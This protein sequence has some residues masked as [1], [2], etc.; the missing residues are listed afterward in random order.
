MPANPVILFYHG[1]GPDPGVDKSGIEAR[2]KRADNSDADL[3][4]PIPIPSSGINYSYPKH[5]KI[6]WLTSPNELIQNLVWFVD[7]ADNILGDPALNWDGMTLWAGIT[8]T[9][10]QGVTLDAAALRAGLTDAISYDSASPLSVLADIV[11]G[12]GEIG[13]GMTQQYVLTQLAV[14]PAA[15]SGLKG[16]R[17]VWYRYEEV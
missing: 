4:N 7:P 6:S 17:N 9:Y 5:Q 10:V 15:L 8:D 11:I 16:R 3:N 14:L 1:A 2:Y 13:P 12:A